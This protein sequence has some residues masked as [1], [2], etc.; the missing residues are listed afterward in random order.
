M[1][2]SVLLCYLGKQILLW[3]EFCV[4]HSFLAALGKFPLY[5]RPG[6]RQ[7]GPSGNYHGHGG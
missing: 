6:L 2:D 3:T 4:W 7:F 1:I 5:E